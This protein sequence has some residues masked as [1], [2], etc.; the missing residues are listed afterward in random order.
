MYKFVFIA[1]IV[2]LV[3]IIIEDFIHS[4]LFKKM[5]VNKGNAKI[6]DETELELFKIFRIK[7]RKKYDASILDES[8]KEEK[9]DDVT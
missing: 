7:K 6:E 2:V 1:I 5:F 3:I 8:S 4:S 9:T